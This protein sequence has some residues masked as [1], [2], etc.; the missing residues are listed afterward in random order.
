MRSTHLTT[1]NRPENENKELG[2]QYE[3]L[4]N[5]MCEICIQ[6]YIIPDS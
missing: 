6:A 4:K 5:I 2:N 3:G 1:V